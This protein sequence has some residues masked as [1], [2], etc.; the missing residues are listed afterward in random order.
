MTTRQALIADP[1]WGSGE[2]P[3]R[4]EACNDP[5]PVRVRMGPYTLVEAVEVEEK[6]HRRGPPRREVRVSADCWALP[7]GGTAS[8]REL[9]QI[10]AR[11]GWRLILPEG[12]DYLRAM[13]RRPLHFVAC[14]TTNWDRLGHS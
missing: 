7:G 9:R 3:T 13:R 5:A 4:A 8:V 14:Q 11:N 6:T 1:G 2:W 12:T 10:A